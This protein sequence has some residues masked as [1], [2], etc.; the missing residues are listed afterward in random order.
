MNKGL[1]FSII[2]DY[3]KNN[4]LEYI[5]NFPL[6]FSKKLWDIIIIKGRLPIHKEL[7]NELDK[8]K[9]SFF[10]INKG[11][12]KTY[13]LN[14]VLDLISNID[15]MGLEPS[16][17]RKI[18]VLFLA[19]NPRDSSRL[20]LGEEMRS[21]GEAIRL[22]KFRDN[23]ELKQQWAVRIVDLQKYLL[24]YKPDIVHFSGHGS[25]DS[26]IV[27]EDNDGFST[28]VPP[29]ALS[30]LFGLFKEHI[31]LVVLNA[32]YSEEQAIAIAE[33]IEYVI[34][35][36][37]SISDEAAIAFSTS[38]YQALAFGENIVSAFELGL[39]QIA[40]FNLEE[41]D[42]PKLIHIA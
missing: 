1:V 14:E 30:D 40:L 32:C 36:S 17:V 15:I 13:F 28:T 27:F 8:I 10:K 9:T 38:L 37:Y 26:E 16:E 12:T 18:C 41:E 6:I 39:N 34:G 23:I 24:M 35:M 31:K 42:I 2:M 7:R 5:D 29:T 20:R 25:R 3:I 33:N 22:G 11:I 19:S 4:D 21:I